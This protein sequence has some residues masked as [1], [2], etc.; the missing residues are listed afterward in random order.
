MIRR[1]RRRTGQTM[2]FLLMVCVIL[3]LVVLFNF[4]V[5]KMITVKLRAQNGGDAAA[6]A[7]ARWQGITLNLI[8]HLN[9]LE[10]VA[11]SDGLARGQTDFPEAQAIAD[12]AAR[13]CFVGPVTGLAAAQ[14]GAKNNGLYVNDEQTASVAAHGAYVLSQYPM[15]YPVEPYTNSPSPPTAW[16]DYGTMLMAVAGQGIAAIPDNTRFFTDY[17]GPHLLLNPSFYDAIGSSDWCWFYHNAYS[18]LQSY[19]SYQDWDPLPL[20]RDPEPM[21]AEYFGLGLMKISYLDTVRWILPADDDQNQSRVGVTEVL[22]LLEQFAE[23]PITSGVAQVA[24][25]WYCYAPTYWREWT[26]FIPDGFPIRGTIKPQYDYV[27][28]DAAVRVETETDRVTP[29]ASRKHVTWSAAAKP[30]GFLE[31]PERPN[32][33]GL[34]LPAFHDVRLIPVDAATGNSGGSRPG[35]ATHIHDH[36]GPYTAQG[37]SGLTPGC[38]YCDQLQTWEN[39]AFRQSGLTWLESNSD[40]CRTYGGG[41]GG[42][43]GG[44]RRGH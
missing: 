30:F 9:V 33:Y 24:A 5:H 4:D 3:A 43:N 29:G 31:G 26:Q 20:V 14:L 40:S 34:V 38:W 12:L 13:L 44:T 23:G 19:Q 18:T 15:Q 7:A 22:A 16:D 28:A 11:I 27:G 36:L 39:S 37:L 10:A 17:Y 25:Q 8:G 1:L 32:R 21:N 2:I 35:W 6:L 41:G 42:G